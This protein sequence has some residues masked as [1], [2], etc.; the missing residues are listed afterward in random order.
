MNSAKSKDG[1][2]PLLVIVGPTAS[3]KT[4]LSLTLAH[5]LS[6]EIISADSRQIY[7]EIDIGS[8]KLPL[9][10]VSTPQGDFRCHDGIPHHLID[11]VPPDQTYTMGDFKRDAERIIGEIHAR[12][13]IP[14]LVGGTGLYI[15]AITENYDLPASKPNIELRHKFTGMKKEDLYQ[16]LLE[17]DPRTAAKIHMNNIPYVTRALEIVEGTGA[18]KSDRT[19]E[20][21]YD[22]F[23]IGISRPREELYTRIDQRVDAQFARGLAEESRRLIEKYGINSNFPSLTSLG[24]KEFV[25]YFNGTATLETVSQKIKAA[26][27]QYAKR[28]IMWF[29]KDKN[30][31]WIASESLDEM[32]EKLVTYGRP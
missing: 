5:A 13:H 28:Q 18:P 6:G 2:I 10:N 24:L 29:K 21:K 1:K 3:G 8:D 14:M 32:Q 11:F 15:R 12:G 27:R 9:Q 30:I 23:M 22:V 19:A 16:L 4:A 20:S 7:K 31:H 17:K 25:P 26:T